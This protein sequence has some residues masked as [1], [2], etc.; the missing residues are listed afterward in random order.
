M[1]S[2]ERAELTREFFLQFLLA[3]PGVVK[4]TTI[5]LS[6]LLHGS[7]RAAATAKLRPKQPKQYEL[8]RAQLRRAQ[9]RRAAA[10][11][12]RRAVGVLLHVQRHVALRRRLCHPRRLVAARP[13]AA[14]G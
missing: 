2:S 7:L 6:R 10:L 1:I 13:V 11:R 5:A 9:L 3:R 8:R 4:F 14:R 12:D